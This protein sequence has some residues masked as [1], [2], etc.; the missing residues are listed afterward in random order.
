MSDAITLESVWATM[1]GRYQAAILDHRLPFYR[2]WRTPFIDGPRQA[3]LAG[4]AA[5][6]LDAAEPPAVL[7]PL[8]DMDEAQPRLATWAGTRKSENAPFDMT[9]RTVL[10]DDYPYSLL[11]SELST[12]DFLAG[13]GYQVRFGKTLSL[14]D[15]QLVAPGYLDRWTAGALALRLVCHRQWAEHGRDG[16][17]GAELCFGLIAAELGHDLTGL[18]CSRDFRQE[19]QTVTPQM[20]AADTAL[21]VTTAGAILTRG[22]GKGGAAR[23]HERL[24]PFEPDTPPDQPNRLVPISPEDDAMTL[25]FD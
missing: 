11:R 10:D 13:L 4:V 25:L 22:L 8:A 20:L 6:F 18:E 16:H 23:Y 5:L 12:S 9:P 7:V 15:K 17:V 1:Q 21:A 24:Q 2:D 3:P 14:K 19:W